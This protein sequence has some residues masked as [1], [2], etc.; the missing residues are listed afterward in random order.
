VNLSRIDLAD[1]GALDKIAEEIFRLVPDIPIPVPVE[2]IA[3]ELDITEIRALETEGFEGGLVTDVEKSRGV[4]LINQASRGQRR[5]FS[6]GHELGHFLSPWHKP[7]RPAGFLCSVEDMRLSWASKQSRAAEMEVEANRFSAQLL[8]PRA[9]FLADIRRRKGCEL[10]HVLGLARDY[11]TSKEATARRYV[12]LHDE[13]CAAIVS[14]HGK[15]LRFYR[16]K[17]FPF[18]DLKNGAPGPPGSISAD[19]NLPVGEITDWEEVDG[20]TWLPSQRGRRAPLVYEQVL[21]QQDGFR[22]TLL[23]MGGNDP[24]ETPIRV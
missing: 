7:L 20:S 13:P 23:T 21:P 17:D 5:R 2:D 8:M 22:L 11:V 6:V 4:I 24:D 9:R 18:L 16:N 15:V 10:E 19:K 14:Q 1:L 3:R 12:E